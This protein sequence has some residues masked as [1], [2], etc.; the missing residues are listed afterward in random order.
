MSESFDHSSREL[1]SSCEEHVSSSKRSL[2]LILSGFGVSF[3]EKVILASIDLSLKPLGILNLVGPGGSGKSTLLRTLTGV[4][5]AQPAMRTWGRVRLADRELTFGGTP[6]R[7]PVKRAEEVGSFKGSCIGLV[8]QDARFLTATV[9]ENLASRLSNRSDLSRLE[10]K[11]LLENM[12]AQEGL[13]ELIPM[14]SHDAVSLSLGLQ[15]RLALV[16]A[17]MLR[18]AILCVDECT[19]SLTEREAQETL[20][21]VGRLAQRCAVIFATHNQAHALQ[22]GGETALLAGGRIQEQVETKEFFSNPQSEAA[23]SF[24]RFGSCMVPS[25]TAIEENL[26]ESVPVPPPLPTS[27][28]E[29]TASRFLGPRGFYWL[30]PGKLGG[31]PRPGIV[32]TTEQDLEALKRLGVT[33]LITLEETL[34]VSQEVC[35][36]YLIKLRHFPIADMCAPSFDQAKRFCVALVDDFKRND[37]V[38]IHCRAGLGRTGTMLA[39]ILIW[40]GSTAMNAIDRVRYTNQ[41]F[42]QSKKQVDF[43]ASFSHWLTDVRSGS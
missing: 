26:A 36:E 10:Q 40:Q 7:A 11:V 23:R 15:R 41:K 3:S 35:V 37:V 2:Y 28:L 27:A 21:V 42:I 32:Q 39:C 22:L 18:P 13:A 20:K 19:A 16:Q 38:A 14:M 9:F 24:V 6:S 25:P 34:T 4:N 8:I 5:D 43:L 17:A 31:V 12:L 30:I 1:F 29:A 33:V